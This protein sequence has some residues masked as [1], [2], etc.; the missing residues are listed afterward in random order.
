MSRAVLIYSA[1]APGECIHNRTCTFG[2]GTCNPIWVNATYGTYNC[3][4]HSKYQ[5]VNC[6]EGNALT[7]IDSHC[8]LAAQKCRL[9]WYASATD[10]FGSCDWSTVIFTPHIITVKYACRL[11]ILT[12]CQVTSLVGHAVGG[13]WPAIHVATYG[14]YNCTYKCKYRRVNCEDF[15]VA[16]SRVDH[17]ILVHHHQSLLQ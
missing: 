13:R 2:R 3:T 5:G 7:C 6:E 16:F 17:E 4:C 15:S 9:I 1:V 8:C 10:N 12:S 14:T 11:R